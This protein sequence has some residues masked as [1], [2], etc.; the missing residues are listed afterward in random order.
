[1]TDFLN[2]WPQRQRSNLMYIKLSK[3]RII[4]CIVQIETE[5][6]V[7]FFKTSSSCLER[8]FNICRKLKNAKMKITF[9]KTETE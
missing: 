3:I 5:K 4:F 6:I 8:N 9:S 7:E 1:V 2:K